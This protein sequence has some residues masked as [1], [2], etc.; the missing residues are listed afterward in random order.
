MEVSFCLETKWLEGRLKGN[1]V[2]TGRKQSEFKVKRYLTQSKLAAALGFQGEYSH[3]S[4]NLTHEDNQHLKNR[5]EG[6]L[7]DSKQLWMGSNKYLHPGLDEAPGGK[8]PGARAFLGW[9]GQLGG[10]LAHRGS[11]IFATD[12]SLLCGACNCTLP[13]DCFLLGSTASPYLGVV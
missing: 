2:N 5:K 9:P 7:D 3:C 12:L 8:Q 10:P 13:G 4:L 11:C 6:I 1:N